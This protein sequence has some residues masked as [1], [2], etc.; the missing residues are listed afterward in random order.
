[1]K[2]TQDIFL[3][4]ESSESKTYLE[5]TKI[6]DEVFDTYAPE[7]FNRSKAVYAFE[8]FHAPSLSKGKII[9]EIKIDPEK[10]LVAGG[11]FKTEAVYAHNLGNSF[12]HLAEKYWSRSMSL[13]EFKKLSLS[14]Q[15][16]M[17]EIP[18]I[19]IPHSVPEKF[20][21]IYLLK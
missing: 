13:K 19:V 8:D 14:E 20:I 5:E 6:I 7:G 2:P 21:R 18:E 9:L 17:Y 11:E 3:D 16:N 12:D 4:K 15:M 10:I 1:M